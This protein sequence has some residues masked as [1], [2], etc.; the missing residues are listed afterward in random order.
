[1]DDFLNFERI[2]KK[3][4]SNNLNL[5]Q[6]QKDFLK[7]QSLKKFRQILITSEVGTG[8][9]VTA[10][11]PFFKNALGK[12][13]KKVIYISPLKSINTTLSQRLIELSS[14]LGISCK[15]EKRTSDISYTTKKKQ[16][17]KV[18]DILLTTPESLTLMIANP[19]ATS[20][21]EDTDFLI[22]DELNEFINSKRGDQLALTISRINAINSKF[23]IFGIS[24][25]T[26]NKSYLVNW[27]SF[28]GKTK[29][30]K[31]NVKKKN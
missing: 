14:H 3:L 8:K 21:L 4:A 24:G 9:T 16:L 12:I 2:Q 22:I 26:S 10:F 30:I 20:L 11:L 28:N 13:Q 17:F 1:M 31:N 25:T 5:Y 6:Y 15:I 27:L 29:I 19:Y 23:E 7:S 18:P